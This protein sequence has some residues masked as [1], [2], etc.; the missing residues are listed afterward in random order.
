VP[1]PEVGSFVQNLKDQFEDCA[2]MDISRR[3]FMSAA[4]M[5][6]AGGVTRGQ[7]VAASSDPFIQGTGTRVVA[8]LLPGHMVGELGQHVLKGFAN[9]QTLYELK[10]AS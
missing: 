1:F 10:L 6:A 5:T 3:I 2:K 9:P 4:P 7:S 8:R